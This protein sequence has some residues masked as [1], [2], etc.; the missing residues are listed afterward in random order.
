MAG[1]SNTGEILNAFGALL[2]YPREGY[3]ER[4][5]ESLRALD[6]GPTEARKL[7]ADFLTFVRSTSLDEMEEL[8][9]RTFDLNPVCSLEAGWHL[10]G[11]AY[12]RGAFLAEVRG[13]LRHHL[14]TENGELPDHLTHVLP[15]LARMPEPARGA[16]ARARLTPAVA[17]MAG[18][19]SDESNP[20][21]KV[22]EALHRT[23][24]AA[25]GKPE[26]EQIAPRWARSAQGG[27]SESEGDFS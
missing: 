15:L 3:A 27:S 24:V 26:E 1:T 4:A 25:F 12:Q 2:V 22:I 8:Y 16:F 11:E 19:F 14:V 7:L 10:Y 18:G 17:R 23:L 5:Q 20:F 6:R 21:R 9:T 13:L